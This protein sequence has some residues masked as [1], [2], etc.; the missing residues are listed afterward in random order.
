MD[1]GGYSELQ[2]RRSGRVKGPIA[3]EDCEGDLRGGDLSE[4]VPELQ[5]HQEGIPDETPGWQQDDE[6]DNFFSDD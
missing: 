1:H 6:W 3:A 2:L 4:V 5:A